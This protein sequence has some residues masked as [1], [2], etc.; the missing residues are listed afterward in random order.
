MIHISKGVGIASIGLFLSFLLNGCTRPE[1]NAIKP[2]KQYEPPPDSTN[3]AIST[4]VPKV[5]TIEISGMKFHP[6][7]ITVRKGDTII[8]K[9]NDLVAH[10]VTAIPVNAWTSSEIPAGASWKMVANESS[11]YFCAIH[12]VMKGK[13]VVE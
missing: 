5:Y 11:N 7:V 10:C 13:M 1:D 8:W 9:N 2:L 12:V 3:V 4:Y 6:E